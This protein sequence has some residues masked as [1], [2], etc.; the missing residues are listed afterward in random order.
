MVTTLPT[1]SRR[2]DNAYTQTWVEVRSDVIDQILQ[3]TVVWALLKMKGCFKSQEGGD[4]ITRSVRYALPSTFTVQKGTVMPDGTVETRTAAYW[5][6]RVLGA[7][8]QRTLL[9]DAANRG[10]Y[11]ILDYVAERLTD[12]TDALKQQYETD[13]LRVED[14]TEADI[15][16][17]Q[18]A[19]I[20]SLQDVVPAYANRDQGTYGR[21]ARSNTWWQPQYQQ[22][23][24]NKDVNM[25]SD[26]KSFFNTVS[27]NQEDP[28]IILTTKTLYE[29]Y[30]DFGLDAVQLV[31]SQKILDLGFKVLK[32]N[33]SELT[34]TPNMTTGDMLF[35]NSGHL[36][37]V[38]DPMVWFAM[39]EWKTIAKQLER[40][41]Q[42]L[43][44]M[45]IISD[46]LR[47]HGRLYT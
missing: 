4:L 10:K 9:E 32:F 25:L 36:E 8:I 39:T 24:A 23:T 43:C 33:G 15:V 30:E 14:T 26:M 7:S 3:A 47:R 27:N 20:Q 35:L 19:H 38:Y 13:V 16:S 5:T 12:T 11:R 46:S 29:T 1:F 28:D 37:C 40:V 6:F 31:G 18:P 42:I 34:W 17:G 41:A 2:I 21:L 45:N 22:F 44:R